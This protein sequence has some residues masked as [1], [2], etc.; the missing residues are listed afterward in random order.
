MLIIR[1]LFCQVFVPTDKEYAIFS[2]DYFM[3]ENKNIID[4]PDANDGVPYGDLYVATAQA[5]YVFKRVYAC[6]EVVARVIRCIQ[7]HKYDPVIYVDLDALCA[8]GMGFRM[9]GDFAVERHSYGQ[10]GQ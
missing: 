9:L 2:K 7:E 5:D 10:Y 3:D 8:D 4:H 6:Y 1:S